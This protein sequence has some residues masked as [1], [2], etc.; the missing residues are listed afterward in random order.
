MGRKKFTNI[1]GTLNPQACKR[2]VLA[3]HYDSKYFQDFDFLGAT[4]SAVPCT[5]ILELLRK[6]DPKLK[7]HK[8]QV[9]DEYHDNHLIIE[10]NPNFSVVSSSP[11]G[12]IE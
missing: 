5:M 9:S 4:D 10:K 12:L 7:Q 2:I 6:L 11:T 3:C 1:V 8:N